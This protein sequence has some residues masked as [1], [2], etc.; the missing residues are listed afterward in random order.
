VFNDG[1]RVPDR[2][3]SAMDADPPVVEAVRAPSP[4]M[5][6]GAVQDG[7]DLLICLSGEDGVRE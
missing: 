4:A 6:D 2:V 3:V 5:L 1:G 7:A